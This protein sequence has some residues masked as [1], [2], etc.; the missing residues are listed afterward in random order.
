MPIGKRERK[1]RRLFTLSD[2]NLLVGIGGL[3][4]GSRH[5]I[6]SSRIGEL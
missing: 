6:A 4:I 3:V 5:H 1:P 2:E